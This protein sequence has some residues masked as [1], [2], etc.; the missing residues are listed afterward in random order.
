MAESTRVRLQFLRY[1][2]VG[3][4]SNMLLYLLYLAL[5]ATVIGPKV[6]M[7]V[8]YATGVAQTFLLNKHWT[9]SYRG[10]V[11]VSMLRYMIT[12]VIGYL[13]NLILLF[14]FVD[15]FGWSHR[16]VQAGAIFFVAVTLFLLLRYWVF[17]GGIR[18]ANPIG[19][20]CRTS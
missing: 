3:V 20:D 6:A 4:V 17:P 7:S 5:T 16:I 18:A 12:Y 9:F 11:A 10:N 15:V 8:V 1:A 19:R 13:I 14:C 2:V